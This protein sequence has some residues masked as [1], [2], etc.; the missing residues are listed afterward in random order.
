MSSHTNRSMAHDFYYRGVDGHESHAYRGCSLS[1][2]ASTALS[3][4]TAIAKVVPKKGF[5]AESVRTDAPETGLTLVSRDSMSPT[6]G[7]HISYVLSASPFGYVGVPLRR[8]CSDFSPRGVAENFLE[9]FGWLA[10]RL[11]TIGNRREFAELLDCRRRVMELVCEEWAKPLRDRRFRKYE[12]LDVGKAMKE[13]Q[14]RRR[15]KAAK[16]AAATRALFAEYFPKAR[17]GGGN[18]CEF[19]RTLCDPCYRS[20]MFPFDADQIRLLRKK[21]DAHAAYV[22]PESEKGRIRTSKYVVVPLDEAKALMKL[23]A[24]GWDMHA[25]K[26]GPYSI[27]RYEGDT[28]QIG[29]HKI[30][31]ENMLALYEAVIGKKF[32]ERTESPEQTLPGGGLS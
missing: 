17:A 25:M 10:S 6:T 31:R 16:A 23:W 32:P 28:V 18:Y 1:Y 29:C 3:Y 14:A 30:P 19:V 13:L 2:R 8:G 21:L 5:G 4:S 22:W 7:R 27:V 9:A 20:A 12:A 26:I 11:N 24:S 15:K